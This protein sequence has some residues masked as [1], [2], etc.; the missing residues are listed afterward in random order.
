MENLLT[1]KE[2]DINDEAKSWN[3]DM[4]LQQPMENKN[5]ETN[6]TFS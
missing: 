3:V 4:S 2:D 6:R 1:E 5:F